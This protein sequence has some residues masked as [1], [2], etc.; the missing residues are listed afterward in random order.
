M[1]FFQITAIFFALFMSYTISIQ[2][3]KQVLSLF[4]ASFWYSLW[5]LFIAFAAFPELL[6]DIVDLLHFSRVFDL[7]VVMAFMV[8][9]TLVF[10]G[11]YSQKSLQRKLEK[12]VRQDALLNAKKN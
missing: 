7:L 3:K 6:I 4:E 1:T 2:A 5:G 8:I 9:T 12:F 10:F 11:Y